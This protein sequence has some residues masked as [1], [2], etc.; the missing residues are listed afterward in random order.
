MRF[1]VPHIAHRPAAT[2]AIC[3]VL[4]AL[5]ACG[6]GTPAAAPP[7]ASES[8]AA[9]ASSAPAVSPSSAASPSASANASA[10]PTAGNGQLGMI[11]E[12]NN[13]GWQKLL[14]SA[15]QP[16][17]V[18][19]MVL[20]NQ[21]G[22]KAGVKEGDV[23]TKINGVATTNANAATREIRK[24][25][26][27]DKVSFDVARVAGAAKVDVTVEPAQ[28]VSLP[29]I[30]NDQLKNAPNDP[31]LL[32]LRATYGQ[33]GVK[34]AVADVTKAM[35]GAPD[36]VS[37][38]VERAT[39]Q[40]ST[41]AAAS[42]KDFDKAASLDPN[43]EPLYVNRSVLFSARKNY[44]QALQDDQKAIQLDASDPAA[45]ANLG[46]GLVNTGNPTKALVAENQALAKDPQFGPALLYR[47]LLQ[48]D[49][50]RSDL[51]NAVKLVRD[52]QLKT[53]AENALLKM[54]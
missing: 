7:S 45:Y 1:S 11:F 13:A 20:P 51:E 38:Y 16:G 34:P 32:F 49:A 2:G 5:A 36:F 27:G 42:L 31:R 40:Q 26:V 52:P 33:E 44:S 9:S 46:I 6:T 12:V 24:L 54:S 8:P 3:T 28:Q 23:I 53:I 41:N 37:A 35:Q 30:I 14:G 22:A 39:L 4:L 29:Q 25:H 48:R 19:V 18:V 21:P 17:M 47:G 10:K 15:A 50:A 43:Y